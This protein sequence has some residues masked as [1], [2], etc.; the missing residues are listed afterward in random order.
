MYK[1]CHISKGFALEKNSAQ[2]GT[3]PWKNRPVK[4]SKA[5][6]VVTIVSVI[7]VKVHMYFPRIFC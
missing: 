1:E 4:E 5:L 6:I 2:C 3:I 7:V